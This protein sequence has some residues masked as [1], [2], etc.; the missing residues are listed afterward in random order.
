M[1]EL[2]MRSASPLATK[3]A[4][5]VAALASIPAV[6]HL[7]GAVY[8]KYHLLTSLPGPPARTLSAKGHEE[9]LKQHGGLCKYLLALHA[10]HGPVL[11]LVLGGEVFVSV[12]DTQ[13]PLPP[14]LPPSF[15]PSFP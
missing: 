10:A 6:L 12:C 14:S 13:V 2:S 9:E 7:L 11:R 3:V 5:G 8:K 4:V 1:L 15:P